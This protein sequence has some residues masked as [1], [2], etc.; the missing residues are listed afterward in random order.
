MAPEMLVLAKSGR[1]P[2]SERLDRQPS[3]ESFNASTK[4]PYPEAST[5]ALADVRQRPGSSQELGSDEQS[6]NWPSIEDT[7]VPTRPN[8]RQRSARPRSRSSRLAEAAQSTTSSS[9]CAP[10][11]KTPAPSLSAAQLLKLTEKNRL[12]NAKVYNIHEVST[13]YKDENRPPSPTSKIRKVGTPKKARDEQ[14]SRAE[15]RA[16]QEGLASHAEGTS[17][18]MTA[19]D[20]AA[21]QKPHFL[22]AGDEGLF[23]SPVKGSSMQAA[24]DRN[25]RRERRNVKWDRDLLKAQRSVLSS[26]SK[27]KAREA[28]L[29]D[30]RAKKIF[31]VRPSYALEQQEPTADLSWSGRQ[32]NTS[33]RLD[34]F[35]NVPECAESTSPIA[36][37]TLVPISKVIYKDDV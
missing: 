26:P 21:L 14:D 3:S 33:R 11:Q 31:R 28:E 9:T 2:S 20:V 27:V 8:I 13:I 5:S 36:P 7:E 35:G 29:L 10:S 23:R 30:A 16:M 37:R 34:T 24:E 1:Q 4:A 18:E 25:L 17:E 12:R 15:R 6:T 32:A 22:A 19:E